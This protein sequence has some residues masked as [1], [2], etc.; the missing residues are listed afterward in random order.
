MKIRLGGFLLPSASAPID[1]F[2]RG[3]AGQNPNFYQQALRDNG[4]IVRQLEDLGFDFVAFSEHHFHLE[5]LELSNN[6]VMLGA[7]AAMQTKRIRIGQMGN[8]LP[9]RNPVLLAEDLAMLD[10][11]SEGRMI[12]GFARGYQARHVATIGQKYNAYSTAKNDPEYAE[13]DRINRELFVEHYDIIRKAWSSS[14]FRHEG[15]HW[16]LPPKG[17]HWDHDATRDMAPGMVGAD[18]QLEK[19]GIAPQTLQ[20]PDSIEIFIPFTMSAETIEWAATVGV[21][22]VIFS[23][24]EEIVHGCLDLF[25]GAA[26]AAGRDLAW[27]AGVGHFR[28]IV[29]ADT[30]AEAA[31]IQERGLGYIWTRWHDWF[32]FNEALRRPGE[33]GRLPNTPAFVRER[34]Y[35]ICGTVDS[36]ATELE[37]MIESL[38]PELI[39]PW[40]AAG[41]TDTDALLKSNELLVEKVLPKIGLELT[42]TEPVL[43]PTFRGATWRN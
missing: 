36:V 9:A 34:G 17:I 23:P 21:K 11:F 5:G 28:D 19:I 40:I 37:Q 24:I 3:F 31:H 4:R 14:L 32:G 13:H 15:K 41:P 26:A 7:W 27:G 42:Q 2:E 33:Q 10:H 1:A 16:Q 22:P 8:V 18:G 43:Q 6:P 35:S 38:K 12:A 25:H 20:D 39:V 29:V 30:A